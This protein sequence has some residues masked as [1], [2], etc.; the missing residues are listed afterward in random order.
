MK[1]GLIEITAIS[2]AVGLLSCLLNLFTAFYL[3]TTSHILG[4]MTVVLSLMDVLFSIPGPLTLLV[5]YSPLYCRALS[6][7]FVFGLTGSLSW[8]CC[9]AYGLYRSVQKEN[10][11]LMNTLFSKFIIMTTTIATVFASYSAL[12]PLKDVNDDGY[13][14]YFSPMQDDSY[15]AIDLAII[16]PS[17]L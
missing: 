5:T 11:E 17:L 7:V 6:F 2:N 3:Q 8:A 9:L 16:L 14:D 1:A 12:A 15:Y 13:C 10:P 4:K